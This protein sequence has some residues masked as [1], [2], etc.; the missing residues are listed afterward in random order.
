MAPHPNS[1]S[2]ILRQPLDFELTK[3]IL[4]KKILFFL[5]LGLSHRIT[6]AV[7]IF[8]YYSGMHFKADS[9]WLFE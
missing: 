7:S 4:E 2:G 9:K 1:K 5:K 6:P 8:P 3:N